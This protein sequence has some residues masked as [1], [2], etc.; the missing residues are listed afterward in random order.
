MRSSPVL[1]CHV[2]VSLHLIDH[3]L[4]ISETFINDSSI[5]WPQVNLRCQA[6]IKSINENILL[7]PVQLLFPSLYLNKDETDNLPPQHKI[8]VI[9]ETR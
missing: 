6:Q 2:D 4:Y 9:E 8:K 5:K 3:R 7:D 1:T